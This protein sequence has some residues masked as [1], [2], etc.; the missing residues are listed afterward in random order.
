M[1]SRAGGPH[2]KGACDVSVSWGGQA[3]LLSQ[4]LLE[5]ELPWAAEEPAVQASPQQFWTCPVPGIP[6]YTRPGLR[7]EGGGQ[8]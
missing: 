5:L 4:F 6:R 3:S 7:E 8:A 1:H 2:L